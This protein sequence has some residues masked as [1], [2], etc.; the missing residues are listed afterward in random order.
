MIR[1]MLFYQAISV[2]N[3]IGS[4]PSQIDKHGA[5]NI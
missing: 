5:V 2:G 3:S 4:V 1:A